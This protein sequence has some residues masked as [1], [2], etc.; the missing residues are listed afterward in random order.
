VHT[1]SF[2]EVAIVAEGSGIH[3]S[4]NGRHPMTA[5]DVVLLRP[6][7]WH[8]YEECADQVVYN[9][10]FSPEL[11]RRELAWTRDDPLLGHL[12]WTGPYAERRRGIL[13][14]HLS[15][16]ER[17]ECFAHLDVLAEL[18]SRPQHLHRGDMI[19]Q[20]ILALGTVARAAGA[21]LTP[22]PAH[23][24]VVE[25]MRLIEDDPAHQWTLTELADQL[26]LAP[27]YLVRL[28]KSVTGLPPM[29]F[30][31]RYRVEMAAEMLLHTDRPVRA[32][33]EH[34]GWP[35]PNYFARRFRAYYG[36]T[37][38]DYRTNFAGRRKL[39]NRV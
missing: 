13:S 23:P 28:F 32:I 35:D 10:C 18:R 36:L 2:V 39:V 30:L 4:L 29:A 24:A 22:E 12:L 5:G 27:G 16:D 1:H 25:G 31:S 21:G 14:T 37:A 17:A 8:T 19:A 33:A 38:S 15:P 3:R 11:L 6:G 7:V 26:H 20:L 34:V 9:C